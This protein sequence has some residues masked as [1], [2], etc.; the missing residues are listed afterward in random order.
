M[1]IIEPWTASLCIPSA[2]CGKDKAICAK[3]QHARTC[4]ILAHVAVTMLLFIAMY[5][6]DMLTVTILNNKLIS[7]S[8]HQLSSC[9]H[10]SFRFD[11]KNYL[12]QGR[13][14]YSSSSSRRS[15]RILQT[16]VSAHPNGVSVNPF[17]ASNL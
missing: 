15:S 8:W 3:L 9:L 5:N 4:N 13:S 7:R 10:Y 12:L 1:R 2:C 14:S 6:N 17:L 11:V 16:G